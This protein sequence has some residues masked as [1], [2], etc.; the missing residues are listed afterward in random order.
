MRCEETG[1]CGQRSSARSNAMARKASEL[2]DFG[3][4]AK[5]AVP[6]LATALEGDIGREV[7]QAAG[8]SLGQ[9]G[10]PAMRTLQKSL[11]HKEAFVREHAARALGWNG[12]DAIVAVPALV[13]L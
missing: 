7:R 8:K 4:A 3:I 9:I 2:G 1:H 10:P 6:A 12:P 11:K 13:G 5:N